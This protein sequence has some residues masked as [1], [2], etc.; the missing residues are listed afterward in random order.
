V[1]GE[2]EDPESERVLRSAGPAAAVAY[3]AT[4]GTPMFEHFPGADIWRESIE[5]VDASLRHLE[6]HRGHLTSLNEHDRKVINGPLAV[7]FSQ[8]GN[9]AA[10]RERLALAE[11]GG[12]TEIAFQPCGDDLP[13]ELEAFIAAARG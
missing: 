5:S 12:T 7:A 11:A 6:V 9:A 4:Y 1:L 10:W 3:H 2:G 13:G 8:S